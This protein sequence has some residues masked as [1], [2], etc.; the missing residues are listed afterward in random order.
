MGMTIQ[1]TQACKACN[2]H[3]HNPK[4]TAREA[5][6]PAGGSRQQRSGCWVRRPGASSREAPPTSVAGKAPPGRER[7]R[8]SAAPG[9]RRVP[10]CLP[11]LL[12]RKP[13]G[14]PHRSPEAAQRRE[15]TR[16]TQA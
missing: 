1:A 8:P 9:A 14:P 12:G 6:G 7:R 10:Y 16:H 15:A 5:A 4:I 2:P 13:G 11:P 3:V